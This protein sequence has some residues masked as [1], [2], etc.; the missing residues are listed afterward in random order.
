[1]SNYLVDQMVWSYSR[2]KA[3][4]DCPYRFYM[5]YIDPT[6]ASPMFFSDFGSFVHELLAQY[7]SGKATKEELVARYLCDFRGKVVGRPPSYD[8]FK[9]YYSKGL[10]CIRDLTPL[11]GSVDAVEEKVFF[12]VGDFP[13]VGFIDCIY[14]DR[15]GE[16][17]IRDHKSRE[18]KPRSKKSQK[19][20]N[21]KILDEYFQQLYLYA[22]PV[23][24]KYSKTPGFLELNCYRNGVC[25]KDQFCQQDFEAAQRWALDSIQQIRNEREWKPNLQWWTCKNLCEMHEQCEYF[26]MSG[27]D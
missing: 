2:I 8:I 22:I 26:N 20:A 4:N 11:D 3:Y 7:Y 21:D 12:Q 6:P 23:K 27:G 19:T 25:I 1:M 18:L 15:D 10:Q 17:V 9:S 14:H 24:N 5:K 13:F 16:L